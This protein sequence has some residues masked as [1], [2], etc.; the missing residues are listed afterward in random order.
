M[1]R[2]YN[3]HSAM[4]LDKLPQMYQLRYKILKMA[5]GGSAIGSLKIS[6][7]S[8]GSLD[9]AST[10]HF[11][12]KH[13]FCS[14]TLSRELQPNL[15]ISVIQLSP[16]LCNAYNMLCIFVLASAFSVEQRKVGKEEVKY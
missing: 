4:D 6:F 13:V 12:Q 5:L 1:G 7:Q 14:K 11:F 15:H 8:N 3:G 10:P 9:G 16:D 2:T